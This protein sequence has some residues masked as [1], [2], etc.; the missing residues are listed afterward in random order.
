MT[1][2]SKKIAIAFL[3]IW[4]VFGSIYVSHASDSSIIDALGWTSTEFGSNITITWITTTE[5][6]IVFPLHVANNETIMNYNV[7]YAKGSLDSTETDA[8]EIKKVVFSNGTFKTQN[9]NAELLLKDLVANT[10]YYFVVQPINK[11]WGLLTTSDQQSFTTPATDAPA[12][13]PTATTTEP[14]LGSAETTKANFTFTLSGNN[15]TVK[16]NEIEGATKFTFAS[17]ESTWTTYT[18]IW[19]ELVTKE[20]F[21]FVIPAIGLY[22]IKIVPVDADGNIVGAEQILTVKI[23]TTAPT[24]GKGTPATGPALNLVLMSTF[25]LMLVYVVY[26]FRTTK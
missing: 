4:A 9:G 11:E 8:S 10:T 23:T 20:K 15:V 12:V 17:K 18:N 25:L 16:W 6:K 22:S 24:P 7:S 2:G 14:S 3:A 21:V 1:K 26:R 5:A 13:V 19:S